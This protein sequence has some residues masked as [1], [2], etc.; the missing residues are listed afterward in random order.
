MSRYMAH[1]SSSS[2]NGARGMFP[3]ASRLCRGSLTT[4]VPAKSR[5]LGA[6]HRNGHR[7]GRATFGGTAVSGEATDGDG[8]ENGSRELTADH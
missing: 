2:K 3:C 1:S 4:L 5:R 6:I 7:I 8:D